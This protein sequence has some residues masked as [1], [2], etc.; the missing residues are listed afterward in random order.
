MRRCFGDRATFAVEVGEIQSPA[1]RAV[2]VWVAG[3]RLTVDDN[4]AFVPSF[5]FAMRSSAARVRRRDIK[6]CPFP[7]HSPE[8][9]FRLL[10][11]DETG[12]AEHF[13]FMRWGETL[14]SVSTYAYLEQTLVI[15]FAFWR[16]SHSFPEG[17]GE[18]FV[19]RIPPDEFAL[20]V[21]T[22]VDLLDSGIV[23]TDPGR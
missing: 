10:Q 4:S 11:A 15:L 20:T 21:E 18:V 9:T 16:A 13:W 3:R 7:G 19:A 8:E 12:F 22:A 17:L 5:S 23:A 6:P 14:D 1:L 2:D